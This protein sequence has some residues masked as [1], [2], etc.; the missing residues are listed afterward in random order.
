MKNWALVSCIPLTCDV[1]RANVK[2]MPFI[3]L[4]TNNTY[5]SELIGIIGETH[6]EEKLNSGILSP[7]CLSIL[8]SEH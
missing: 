8:T 6:V 5:T 1:Y 3:Q 4:Q 7:L 2:K